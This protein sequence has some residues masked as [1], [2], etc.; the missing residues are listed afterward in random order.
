M[1]N[2]NEITNPRAENSTD[3]QTGDIFKGNNNKI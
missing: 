1:E 3:I 2:E